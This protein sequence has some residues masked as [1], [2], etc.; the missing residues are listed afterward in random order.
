ML[1]ATRLECRRGDRRLFSNLSFELKASDCL[2]VQGDNGSG[3]TSLLR[4]V[5]GLTPPAR[6]AICWSGQP[7]NY[8]NDAYRREL[9]Y[10]GHQPGLKEEL[11]VTE[12]LKFET[13]LAGEL[14]G[15]GAVHDA[16]HQVGLKDKTHLRVHALSQGQKRRLNLARLV[17]QKRTLWVLDEPLTALDTR[18]RQW[19]T[20]TIDRH[21]QDGGMAVLTTHQDMKLKHTPSLIRIGT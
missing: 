16:L 15:S 13:M 21:L 12:N 6:G 9:L 20:D 11:S 14:V 5:V 10:I 18:A 8:V 17:L 1:S 7:V 19:V 4:M 3:K 2:M